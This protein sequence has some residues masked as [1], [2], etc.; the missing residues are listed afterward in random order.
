MVI[1]KWHMVKKKTGTSF[2]EQL[3][4]SHGSLWFGFFQMRKG[5]RGIKGQQCDKGS[6]HINDVLASSPA[7]WH[8]NNLRQSCASPW[9]LTDKNSF[10]RKK[11][12]TERIT[13]FYMLFLHFRPL[14]I[15]LFIFLKYSSM[16]GI[17]KL[18]KFSSLW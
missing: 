1:K 13:I 4:E 12:N 14:A 6:G 5:R 17:F 11:N 8:Q 3:Q 7:E 9:L 10:N 15:P 2:P 18:I 16:V